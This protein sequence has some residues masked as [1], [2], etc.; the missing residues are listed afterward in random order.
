MMSTARQQ[1]RRAN[2]AEQGY[3]QIRSVDGSHPFKEILGTSVQYQARKRKGGRVVYFNFTLAKEM[4]LIAKDHPHRF[5]RELTQVLLDTFLV[6]SA[7]YCQSSTRQ[8]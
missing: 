3:T 6:S 5:N 7:T 4:G 2:K 8:T 1:T